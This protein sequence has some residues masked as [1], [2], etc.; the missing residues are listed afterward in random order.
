MWQAATDVAL[1]ALG[2]HDRALEADVSADPYSVRIQ[3]LAVARFDI[4]AERGLAAI[5]TAAALRDYEQWLET[6]VANW[7]AYV[8]DTCPTLDVLQSLQ[9]RLSERRMAWLRR[10]DQMPKGRA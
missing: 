3:D 10:A 1:G 9:E 5:E 2:E 8:A 4:W 6:Y 7:L